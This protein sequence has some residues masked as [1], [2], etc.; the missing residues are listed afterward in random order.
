MRASLV[1]LLGLA[2]AAVLLTNCSRSR[3]EDVAASTDWQ[4]VW[5]DEFDGAAG[6]TPGADKWTYATGGDG[7]G[8]EELQHYT[9]G[10]ENASLDGQ[11]NLI[12]TARVDDPATQQCWYGPCRYTSARLTTQNRLS[13]QYG[14]FDAR[15]GCRADRASGLPSGCSATTSTRPAGRPQAR[16]T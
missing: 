11:G 9:D 2:V 12:V 10:P 6:S 13:Q 7:W 8:N 4:L 5:S 3:Y 15:T 1:L 14:Y 16:S